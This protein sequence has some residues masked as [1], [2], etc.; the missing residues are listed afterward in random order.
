MEK[1]HKLPM[2]FSVAFFECPVKK[3]ERPESFEKETDDTLNSYLKWF[4]A[5]LKFEP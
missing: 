3:T 4:R 1:L 5:I 2:S